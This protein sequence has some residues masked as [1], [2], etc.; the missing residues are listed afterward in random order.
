MNGFGAF[1]P[2]AGAYEVWSF[3]A[4]GRDVVRPTDPEIRIR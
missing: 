3:D 4:A 1:E 2:S